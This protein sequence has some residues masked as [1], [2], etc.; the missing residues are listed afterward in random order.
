MLI[1]CD[2]SKAN[3]ICSSQSELHFRSVV[4]QVHSRHSCNF[5]VFGYSF[6]R[7]AAVHGDVVFWF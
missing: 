7:A 4:D 5:F 1:A 3:K 6:V 2:L